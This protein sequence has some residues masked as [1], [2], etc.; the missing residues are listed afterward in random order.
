MVEDTLLKDVVR[1]H[2]AS[3]NGPEVE[4]AALVIMHALHKAYRELV[5]LFYNKVCAGAAAWLR[6]PT[7]HA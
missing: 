7:P 5:K 1:P 6:P 4:A 3:V 2:L